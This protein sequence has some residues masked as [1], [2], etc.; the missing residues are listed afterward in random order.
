MRCGV[1][2]YSRCLSTDGCRRVLLWGRE[3]VVFR[4]GWVLGSGVCLWIGCRCLDGDVSSYC[5]LYLVLLR[6]WFNSMC[7]K[8]FFCLETVWAGGVVLVRGT[9]NTTLSPI[10]DSLTS[11]RSRTRYPETDTTAR[12]AT[13]HSKRHL[14]PKRHHHS[15]RHPPLPITTQMSIPRTRSSRQQHQ[16]LETPLPTRNGTYGYQHILNRIQP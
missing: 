14:H 2:G 9:R 1:C 4:V 11:G 10:V 7:I 6:V 3:R 16:V 5:V 15:K 13:P 8:R 12:N